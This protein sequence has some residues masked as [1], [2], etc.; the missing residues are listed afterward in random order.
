MANYESNDDLADDVADEFVQTNFGEEFLPYN[1]LG[2]LVTRN[3]VLSAFEH[4]NILDAEDLVDFV[5]NNARR[6]FLILVMMERISLLRGL[7]DNGVD[8]DS[9]PIGF[10]KENKE[11]CGYSL[12]GPRYD[13]PQFTVFNEWKRIDRMLFETNQWKFTAPVFGGST[14][15]FQ[16]SPN[17]RLP[18]MKVAAKPASSGFFSEV[19]R[20]EIHP[21]HIPV[22]KA[23][24]NLPFMFLLLLNS[25]CLGSSHRNGCDCG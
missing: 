14:F 22:L 21:A 23:V 9:L 2:E 1:K 3:K 12:E 13:R 16:F 8:D 4:A 11:H 17:R 6:I 24:R 15:R 18:F 19:S 20:I 5:L 25:A 10:D 7:Q